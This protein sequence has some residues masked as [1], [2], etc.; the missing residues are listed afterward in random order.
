MT[1]KIKIPIFPEYY[2][3]SIK[4]LN[5]QSMIPMNH[6]TEKQSHDDL[7]SFW[8]STEHELVAFKVKCPADSS[9]SQTERER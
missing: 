4:I 5:Q 7:D 1:L 6:C 3:I 8:S 9:N 2:I